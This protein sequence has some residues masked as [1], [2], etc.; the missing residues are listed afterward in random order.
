M[1]ALGTVSAQFST[2]A[3]DRIAALQRQ[4]ARCDACP[5]WQSATQTVFG[6]GPADAEIMFVGEQPDD[7][8]DSA[9]R[10]FVGPAGLLL[11]RALAEAGIDRKLTYVT[12]AVKHFKFEPRARQRLQKAPS[13]AE[14]GVCKHWL[15]AE[16]E[17][18]RPKLIVALGAIAARAIARKPL[19]VNANRGRALYLA[20]G[21]N[22]FVTVHPSSLLRLA[23]RAENSMAYSEFVRDL[24]SAAAIASHG[25]RA[26]NDRS[27]SNLVGNKTASSDV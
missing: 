18:V 13:V 22:L 17:V 20:N 3:V 12:N 27:S 10:P 2:S 26:R 8:E 9:G 16:I 25:Y 1:N 4:A 5:L 11:D 19:Q 23:G 6:E 7:R 21:L 15:F 14:I 24:R